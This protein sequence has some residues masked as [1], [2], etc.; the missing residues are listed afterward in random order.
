V[1]IDASYRSTAAGHVRVSRVRAP[2]RIF[3]GLRSHDDVWWTRQGRIAQWVLD[4]PGTAAWVDREPAPV[5]GLPG[6]SA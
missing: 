5:S 3:T 4:H 1:G 6:R 2:D